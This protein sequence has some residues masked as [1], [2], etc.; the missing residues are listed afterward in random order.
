MRPPI[1]WQRI[2]AAAGLVVIVGLAVGVATVSG[3]VA[4]G[5][6]APPIAAA[7]GVPGDPPGTTERDSLGA[8]GGQANAESGGISGA[9]AASKP[10]QAISA[11]GRWVA[12]VS[13]ATNLIPGSTRPAGGLYV[14]DR[15]AGTTTAVPWTNGGPFPASVVAAEPVI[16]R[17]GGVVAFTAIVTSGVI[18]AIAVPTTTPYV[19]AWDRQTNTTSLVSVSASGQPAAGWQ[20]SISADGRYVAYTQWAP[21]DTTPPVLSNLSA[22][23]THVGGCT[24]PTSTTIS[25]TATDPDDPVASVTLRYT[26][27]GTTITKPMSPGGGNVWQA[28]VAVDSS[29]G[30]APKTIGFSVQGTDSHGNTSAPLSSSFAWDSCIQ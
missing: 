26:P 17:D 24:G 14:R 23:P 28:S 11:D 5:V 21:P 22:N 15:Q 18:G 2:L 8:T 4:P 20:P 19:F 10:S 7:A 13:S 27:N 29:W 30:S 25:V 12:F 9:V 3:R 6:D 1:G 16:S